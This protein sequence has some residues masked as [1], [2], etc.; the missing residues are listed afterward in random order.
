MGH[1]TNKYIGEI[2]DLKISISNVISSILSFIL[3]QGS[4]IISRTYSVMDQI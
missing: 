3:D 2:H 1:I 4:N